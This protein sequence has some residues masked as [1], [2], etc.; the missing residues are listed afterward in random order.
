[1]KQSMHP[2][3]QLTRIVITQQSI[4][5]KR[6]NDFL[7][8][9]SDILHSNDVKINRLLASNTQLNTKLQRAETERDKWKAKYKKLEERGY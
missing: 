9:L 2:L 1:M 7:L 4:R 8:T 6:L 5:V 3:D